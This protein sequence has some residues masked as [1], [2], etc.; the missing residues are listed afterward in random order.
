MPPPFFVTAGLRTC[1]STRIESSVDSRVKTC[2]DDLRTV[3]RYAAPPVR[4]A[5][6]FLLAILFA[7]PTHAADLFISG[8]KLYGGEHIGFVDNPGVLIREGRVVSLGS[9]APEG[10]PTLDAMG[11]FV[12]PG[13]TDARISAIRFPELDLWAG[14]GVTTL[15]DTI[16]GDIGFLGT[17]ASRQKLNFMYF[18]LWRSVP[19]ADA[20]ADLFF[21][22]Y[23]LTVTGGGPAAPRGLALKPKPNTFRQV[24]KEE[25]DDGAALLLVSLEST[26]G[27]A[28]TPDLLSALV[29][30][31][32]HLGRRVVAE[33]ADAND[34]QLAL[35]AG[36]DI[37]SGTPTEPIPDVLLARAAKKTILIASLDVP[38]IAARAHPLDASATVPA[39]IAKGNVR[40][41]LIAGGR[42]L[43]GSGYG[44]PG[45]AAGLPE[46]EMA[47]LGEAG[48]TP[49]QIFA[50]LTDATA[51]ATG[52]PW[53]GLLGPGT[54][55]DAVIL[56]ADPTQDLSTLKTPAAVVKRGR[57]LSGEGVSQPKT[58]ELDFSSYFT[59][60]EALRSAEAQS[61]APPRELRFLLAAPYYDFVAADFGLGAWTA[62]DQRRE[63]SD[64]RLSGFGSYIFAPHLGHAGARLSFLRDNYDVGADGDVVATFER[65]VGLHAS[66]AGSGLGLSLQGGITR[67]LPAPRYVLTGQDGDFID[68]QASVSIGLERLLPRRVH[69]FT[70]T[71][72]G[73]GLFQ[74][75]PILAARA[76]LTLALDIGKTRLTLIGDSATAQHGLPLFYQPAIFGLWTFS[77]ED[78]RAPRLVYTRGDLTYTVA[79]FLMGLYALQLTALGEWAALDHEGPVHHVANV[80]AGLKLDLMGLSLTLAPALVWRD[81]HPLDG[82]KVFGQ[83]W[84]LLFFAAPSG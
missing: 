79:R 19:Y 60:R 37:L 32:H 54:L 51:T 17:I 23:A 22:G 68:T 9:V 49:A 27:P 59:S 5:P 18:E 47:L 70:L 62:I 4:R 6:L 12:A 43:V 15:L 83:Q 38:D 14:R 58:L 11:R 81:G 24:V 42:V 44:T 52:I 75:R 34:W 77:F 50:G 8:G 1:Q 41:F 78:R 13:L 72:S 31:A 74:D 53:F 82:T 46:R 36:V 69:S 21:A 63:A 39:E 57:V 10:V 55:G 28:P 45:I 61:A 25:V 71:L 7:P 20:A 29:A 16:G 2:H 64:L 76:G 73:T 66:W 33:A 26:K 30:E 67:L 84:Q 35:D 56:D 65:H 48:L 80:G 3:S 40:R